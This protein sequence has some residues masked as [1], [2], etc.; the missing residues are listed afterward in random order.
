M[1]YA[2]LFVAYT[3][4]VSYASI[5][6]GRNAEQKAV[7]ALHRSEQTVSGFVTKLRDRIRKF[8]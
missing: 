4:A 8:L 1:F 3:A 5:R 2:F 6:Y 7:A